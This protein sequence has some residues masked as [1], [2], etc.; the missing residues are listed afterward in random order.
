MTG[1]IYLSPPESDTRRNHTSC[2]LAAATTTYPSTRKEKR[3]ETRTPKNS[4]L[5]TPYI[6]HNFK[7]RHL[8]FQAGKEYLLV[9]GMLYTPA[10]LDSKG[11]KEQHFIPR[12]ENVCWNRR[13]LVAS[14]CSFFE[15]VLFVQIDRNYNL[16]YLLI[17]RIPEVVVDVTAFPIGAGSG[18]GV[19]NASGGPRCTPVWPLPETILPLTRSIQ[20]N[21]K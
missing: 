5:P 8:K 3:Q 20:Y 6:V 10:G 15:F 13:Q 4:S 7:D 16:G 21:I 12:D 2:P 17:K 11:V 19:R 18:S 9:S 14:Y 1:V